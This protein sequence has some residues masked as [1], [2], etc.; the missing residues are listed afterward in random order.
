MMDEKELTTKLSLLKNI[1]PRENWVIFAKSQILS[2]AKEEVRRSWIEDV[3]ATVSFLRYMTKPAYVLPLLLVFVLGGVTLQASKNSLPGDALFTVRSIFEK[4][5]LNNLELVQKRMGDLQKIAQ[6]NK[7]RNLS[8]TVKE[9]KENVGRVSRNI[10]LLVDKEPGKALQAGLE[11]VQLQ[12]D[13]AAIEQILGTA[14]DGDTEKELKSATKYL[15]ENELE[16]LL[17]RTLTDEQKKLLEEGIIA[18]QV[19]DYESALEAVWKISN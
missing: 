16:D 5:T 15:V 10:A 6:E 4:A 14:L 2:L 9:F 7:V 1:K 19:E 3:F 18:Y 8:E 11:L 12:K 17:T 13:K